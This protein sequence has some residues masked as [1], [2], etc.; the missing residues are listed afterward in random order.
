MTTW[1]PHNWQ[2]AL[3]KIDERR[4][5]YI[6]GNRV[7]AEV[8]ATAHFV[9]TAVAA[10]EERGAFY[11]ALSGGSTPNMLY[12]KL[13]TAPYNTAIDWSRVH[14]FW[15]DERCVPPTDV[16]SNYRM[17]MEAGLHLLPIPPAQIH[18]M[19]GEENPRHAAAIYH[20][21]IEKLVPGGC[22]DLMMLGLGEDGHTA[23]LFPNTAAL[24]VKDKLA[25]A[26]EVPSVKQSQRLTLTLPCINAARH[27]VC[28][29]LGKSKA[30]MLQQVLYNQEQPSFPAQLIGSVA[31]P[32]LWIVDN[33]AAH[34]LPEK[35][36]Y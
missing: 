11:A 32:A 15:S 2:Q 6:A 30:Y 23:S 35:R 28:Y 36:E 5:L 26:N 21:T 19:Q 34:L 8:F 27:I 29:A 12:S 7:Q 14:L 24:A 25:A 17:A 22:F 13:A 18:R 4:L 9:A 33:E 10:I 20:D 31:K 1:L 16:D 3:E